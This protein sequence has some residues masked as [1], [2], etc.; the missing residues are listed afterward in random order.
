MKQT[1][2]DNLTLVL[3]RQ[4]YEM[5]D[6]GIK[7]EEYREIKK[8][9]CRLFY[10]CWTDKPGHYGQCQTFN[11]ETK[12][13]EVTCPCHKCDVGQLKRFKTVTFAHGYA[14]DRPT[15]VYNVKEI[16]ID[17]GKP[18]WGAEPGVEYIVVRLGER[19]R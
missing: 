1:S 11:E 12:H 19:I 7:P 18:E 15:M 8:H 2:Y 3:K 10:E 9:N 13:F 14:T 17:T 4:W 5:I 6:A 16:V